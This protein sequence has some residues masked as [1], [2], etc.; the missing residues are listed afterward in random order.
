MRS[1]LPISE[2]LL[3]LGQ[4][5]LA[6]ILSDYGQER[7]ARSMARE[8]IAAVRHRRIETT[9]ELVRAALP[10]VPRSA[11]HGRIHF[12]TRLF[13]ALRIEVNDELGALR[14]LLRQSPEVIRK[15][16]RLVVIS[17]HSL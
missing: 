5:E 1:R 17:Y 4:E 6:Q 15:G 13:Q 11:R 2:R 9:A 14:D 7:F 10:G 16:G 3:E 12:A 8:I